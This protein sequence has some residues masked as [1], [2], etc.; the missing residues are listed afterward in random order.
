MTEFDNIAENFAS[1]MN[2][3]PFVVYSAVP[4]T[5]AV[6]GNLRGLRVLDFGCG[7][8]RL[9]R[10]MA[11]QGADVVGFD[12][13]PNM[14]GLAQAEESDKPLGIRYFIANALNLPL[15]GQFD[16]VLANFVIHLSRTKAEM[17]RMLTPI[18]QNLKIGGR[19]VIVAPNLE[20][21]PVL[22]HNVT[23]EGVE[24]LCE[25]DPVRVTLHVNRKPYSSFINY[26]WRFQTYEEVAHQ[27]GFSDIRWHLPK[28]SPEGLRLF[29]KD[30][31]EGYTLLPL[32]QVMEAFKGEKR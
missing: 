26:Y 29:G 7:E 25:G 12:S 31:W 13:A 18:H 23:V 5:F 24:P 17:V 19:M 3:D 2:R 30:F 1:G 8:G 16:L 9:S 11:A 28:V 20:V 21:R 4:T 22:R 27:V 15:L 32:W 6:L 10:M 14:I